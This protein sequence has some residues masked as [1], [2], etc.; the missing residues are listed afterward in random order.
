MLVQEAAVRRL[1]AAEL[2]RIKD[3]ESCRVLRHTWTLP[4]RQ[5]CFHTLA[6]RSGATR[7]P[8]IEIGQ[9]DGKARCADVADCILSTWSATRK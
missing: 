4:Q 5:R 6:G 7:D 1:D 3:F 2:A 8:T 9:P